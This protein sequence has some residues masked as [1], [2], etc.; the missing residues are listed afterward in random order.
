MGDWNVSLNVNDHLAGGSCTTA[1]MLDFQEC[2]EDIEIDR[3][4]GNVG[5][6]GAFP[7]SHVVFLPH[8]TFDHCHAML[9][10]PNAIKKQKRAFRFANFVID[11]LEF[12]QSLKDNWEIH[13]KGCDMF[14][15]DE[16]IIL[17]EYCEAISD[18]E[19]FLNQQ[20][21]ID[22]LKDEDRNSKFFYAFLKC[23]RN[24]SRI[25]MVQNESGE[26]FYDEKVHEQFV[27]YFKEF[28]GKSQFTQLSFIDKIQFDKTVSQTDDD[29]MIRQ[30][31]CASV[32]DFF[33]KGKMLGE[34]N[35]TLIALIPKMD[36][37]IKVSDF[38]LKACCN[39][40]YKCIS[41]ILTDRIKEALCY[42]VDPNQIAF[43]PGRQITYNIMI[44]QELLRGYDWKNGAKR[45]SLKIDLHKAYDTQNWD[46]LKDVL[47]KCKFPSKMVNLIMTCVST[48]SFSICVN[49]NRHGY[50]K[51]V[52]RHREVKSTKVVKKAFDQFCSMSGL[53]PNMGKSTAFFRNLKEHVKHEI[54]SILPFKVGTLHVSYVGVP[55]IKK[56]LGINDCKKL[57]DK[58]K[59]KVLNWKKKMPTYD[60]RLQLIAYVLS[61]IHVYWALV[62]ILPK[63][64]IKDIDRI[65]K[66]FLWNQGDM[67]NG[68]AKS[69]RNC[70]C[71]SIWIERNKRLFANEVKDWE[72][73]LKDLINIVRLKLSSKKVKGVTQVERIEEL[74]NVKM[75]I[76]IN[77]EIIIDM[78]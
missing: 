63:T 16:A 11:K 76:Q 44:T 27:I 77:E 60:G 59:E 32:K 34:V 48:T 21:K 78:D 41:K 69:L 10:I 47:I 33:S 49:G 1:D 38:R 75:N 39:V 55:L 26:S 64:V 51:G 52:L 45:V 8:L 57:I 74:W 68:K 62:F 31:V 58:L 19:K 23:R 56:Q 54:L 66:G 24:K 50:F 29:W 13:V 20:D 28:L 22:W 73:V 3:I 4:L 7:S 5:F 14:K 46:F 53:K 72:T 40:I 2:L 61:A 70:M 25:S 9:I 35:D 12:L 71:Y 42:L 18:E 67:K 65:M 17:K 36:T 15:L 6:M 30:D 43:L 37:P